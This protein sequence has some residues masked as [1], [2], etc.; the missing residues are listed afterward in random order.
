MWVKKHTLLTAILINA[1]ILAVL[2]A[3]FIPHFQTNDD[4]AILTLAGHVK[5][6]SD[7]HVVYQ[8]IILGFIYEGLYSLTTAVPWYAL[9]QYAALF[10]SFTAA[11]WVI[12]KRLGVSLGIILCTLLITVF[13]YESYIQIQFS[14]TAGICTAAGLLLLLCLAEEDRNDRRILIFGILLSLIGSWYRF[15]AFLACAALMTGIGL[16]I[17]LTRKWR[18]K[19]AVLPQLQRIVLPFFLV[20]LLCGG[21]YA[22]DRWSY[23]SDPFMDHY[24]EYNRKR[25][26]LMDY[27]FPDYGENPAVYEKNGITQT[28]LSMFTSWNFADPDYFNIEI[29]DELIAAKP[30]KH[31]S[32]HELK[33]TALELPAYFL[34]LPAFW[35]FLFLAVLWL[36]S[37][38]QARSIA[39]MVYEA[40]LFGIVY[41][42]LI[43]LG[44]YSLPWVDMGFFWSLS[45]VAAW[46][47]RPEKMRLRLLLPAAALFAALFLVQFHNPSFRQNSRA[48]E[49]ARRE[50]YRSELEDIAA[51]PDHLYI[52]KVG[53]LSVYRAYGPF[54]AIPEN[55]L[56][57]ILFLGGWSCEHR[58]YRDTMQKWNIE[59][60]FRDLVGRDD[61]LLVDNEIGSTLR[62]L[63]EHY[64]RQANAV[65]IKKYRRFGIYQV[66]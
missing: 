55:L 52:A 31:I 65:R 20:L 15:K 27:G 63:D 38:L 54:D 58:A 48:D 42:F 1:A 21:S 56:S 61:I 12:L 18:E 16:F 47:I 5:S 49:T 36:I 45:L 66:T 28:T 39:V 7:P 50:R 25:S 41:L 3:L 40:L 11:A 19:G 53:T 32:R 17:L 33:M 64:T 22:L 9:L 43:F 37:H 4:M 30:E 26:G 51:D 2:T 57:N 24:L 10:A 59:N 6:V 13:G 14:K 62:Y 23:H 29:M 60:P 46:M 34:S 35:V 8:N 44:R